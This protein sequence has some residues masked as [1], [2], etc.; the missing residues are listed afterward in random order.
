[1]SNI[2]KPYIPEYLSLKEVLPKDFYNKYK[3]KGEII[4]WGMW[5]PGLL[6]SADMLRKEFGS[7][8]CNNWSYG[9]NLQYR[10]FRPF[11]CGVGSTLSQHK[12]FNAL[13][14]NF[15]NHDSELVRE[16]IFANKDKL[17]ITSVECD[18]SWVHIDTRNH[19]HKKYGIFK[20]YP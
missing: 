6:Y 17:F 3:H 1:M 9:G 20:T 18:V 11:D 8:L 14:L 5:N 13:D 19:N 2:Y 15:K 7:M 12:T 4:L 16:Y 10:G